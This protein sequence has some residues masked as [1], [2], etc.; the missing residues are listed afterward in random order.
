[1]SSIGQ[2]D[3]LTKSGVEFDHRS[4]ATIRENALG[5]QGNACADSAGHREQALI[6]ERT[7]VGKG[8]AGQQLHPKTT[9]ERVRT[10]ERGRVGLGLGPRNKKWAPQA[11]LPIRRRTGVGRW[12]DGSTENRR[13]HDL[14]L[15][16]RGT[17]VGRRQRGLIA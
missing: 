8:Y 16:L 13:C 17:R 3:P 7:T 12:L 9:A 4:G 14:Q 1:M 2:G 15:G 6:P 5:H 10:F 11:R